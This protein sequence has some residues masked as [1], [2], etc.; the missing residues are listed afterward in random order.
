MKK[1]YFS[2]REAQELI[3][4]IREDAK[5][6]ININKLLTALKTIQIH[7]EDP[8]K[9]KLYEIEFNKD[10]RRVAHHFYFLIER[11]QKKGCIIDDIEKG[12]FD[13]Y[14]N[15]HDEDIVFCWQIQEENIN[16]WHSPEDN[17][18]SRKSISTIKPLL[19]KVEEKEL[20]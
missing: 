6:L 11:L 4:S 8:Y 7:H 12:Y 2:Y 10:F 16:G 17:Y 15:I 9:K 5:T 19:D 18:N 1:K 13:I 20:I 14:S 3:N